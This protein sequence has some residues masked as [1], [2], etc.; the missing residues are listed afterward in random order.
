MLERSSRRLLEKIAQAE[1]VG[2]CLRWPGAPDSEGYGRFYFGQ[3]ECRA[4]RAVYELLKGPIPDKL[5]IDHLCRNR[6]CIQAE[7]LEAVTAREN[8]LR[9]QGTAAINARKTHCPR[10]HAYT[11][12]NIK[13]NGKHGRNCRI[14]RNIAERDRKRRIRELASQP[15]I[16]VFAYS[17][18]P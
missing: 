15:V 13:R 6:W 12:E 3:E 17:R 18:V 10:G 7:H 4:H 2:D 1:R 5:Q 14:C 11:P 16:P 9:G 8:V